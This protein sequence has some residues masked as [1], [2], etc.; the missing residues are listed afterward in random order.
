MSM[1]GPNTIGSPRS[2]EDKEHL[3]IMRELRQQGQAALTWGMPN[4]TPEAAVLGMGLVLRDRLAESAVDDRAAAAAALAAQM[5]DKTLQRMAQ[6]A[7]IE[8]VRG[9]NFCCYAAVS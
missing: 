8:C 4:P 3:R 7:A 1:A 2:R 5:L 6:A 9:C